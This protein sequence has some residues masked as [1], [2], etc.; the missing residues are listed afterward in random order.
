MS[1]M[2]RSRAGFA[3]SCVV[4][5]LLAI[6]SA[7]LVGS[8]E[9]D[10]KSYP[11][12]SPNTVDDVTSGEKEAR[13]PSTVYGTDDGRSVKVFDNVAKSS[14]LKTFF[15][16]TLFNEWSFQHEDGA[17]GGEMTEGQELSGPA[18]GNV[19]WTMRLDAVWFDQTKLGTELRNIV[20]GNWPDGQELVA[21]D[22]RYLALRR[23]DDIALHDGTSGENKEVWSILHFTHQDWNS[24]YYA[25]TLFY[26]ETEEVLA[27]VQ[28]RQ[29][30]FIAWDASLAYLQ[31]PPSMGFMKGQFIL[32]IRWSANKTLQTVVEKQ[33][34]RYNAETEHGKEHG[35]FTGRDSGLPLDVDVKTHE[36]RHFVTSVTWK[37]N[38]HV[39]D[40]LLSQNDVD[41]LRRYAKRHGSFLFGDY[42]VGDEGSDN[43]QWIG[44]YNITRFTQSKY[45]RLAQKVVE[46]VSGGTTT[47]YPYD[48]ACNVVR[49]CDHTR[50]HGDV[51]N[52]KDTEWTFLIYLSPEWS[53][54]SYG[55]T[56]WFTG[57]ESDMTNDVDIE[58]EVQPLF[59]RIAIFEGLIP[60]A[61]R[62]P[63]ASYY[64]PRYSFAVKMAATKWHASRNMIWEEFHEKMDIL[65]YLAISHPDPAS[66]MDLA[67][68][69]DSFNARFARRYWKALEV[70]DDM[71][72]YSLL[73]KVLRDTEGD[74]EKLHSLLVYVVGKLK[75]Q[76]DAFAQYALQVA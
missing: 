54:G 40:G 65:T 42:T 52:N 68:N 67:D 56:A 55:E 18:G 4:M 33:R 16:L 44:K 10:P 62:P 49:S 47:W 20:R 1:A 22:V 76:I 70:G 6:T 8:S 32:C 46:Y 37:K 63:S 7:P 48:V 5:V 9:P 29:Q 17:A 59:G 72:R 41:E 28:P 57:T 71:K 15:E 60:H 24:N 23:G 75:Q 38:V 30:R 51:R 45:W 39:F 14:L 34:R 25:E 53:T 35:L 3:I 69:S 50:I 73:E 11:F 43:V 2:A 19:P 26:D 31:R 36:S 21:Y 61:A 13:S 74:G 12:D 58:T 66:V 27:T 64:G